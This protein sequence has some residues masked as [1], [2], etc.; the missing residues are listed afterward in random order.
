MELFIQNVAGQH[1]LAILLT[2]FG[3]ILWVCICAVSGSL[4]LHKISISEKIKE[5]ARYRSM[6]ALMILYYAFIIGGIVFCIIAGKALY[7]TG[8]FGIISILPRV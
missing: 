2:I 5:T 4:I 1:V 8:T 6:W 3:I 7:T